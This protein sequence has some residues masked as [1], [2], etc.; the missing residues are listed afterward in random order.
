MG[1][2][3][4]GRY[5]L[6]DTPTWI[7][8]LSLLLIAWITF[9]GAAVGVREE[10]HLSIDFVREAMPP[11]PRAVLRLL[12]DAMVIVFSAIMAWQGWKLVM[13]NL[14]RE[15]PMIG[16]PEAWRAA[17]LV[18]FGVLATIFAL[19]RFA[20]RLAPDRSRKWD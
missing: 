2:L 18:V 19:A 5:V 7:E 9:V 3:V 4:F 13:A 16:L 17:P 6:N 1:W 20:Q 8:Q 10:S 12:A 15:I 11:L 14:T